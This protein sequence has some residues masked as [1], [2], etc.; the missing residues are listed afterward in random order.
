MNKILIEIVMV[1]LLTM[2]AIIPLGT[3]NFIL[4]PQ[5]GGVIHQDLNMSENLWYPCPTHNVGQL[6]YQ[7]DLGNLGVIAGN[8][9]AE[10]I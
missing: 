10:K 7:S 1:F 6:W 5:G 9:P 8:H 3:G 4:P 2:I